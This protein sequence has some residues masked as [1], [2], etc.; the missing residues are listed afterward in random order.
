ML[1]SSSRFCR[2]GIAISLASIEATMY[3][4]FADC[5]PPAG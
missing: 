3:T 5:R 1:A 2:R 4:A